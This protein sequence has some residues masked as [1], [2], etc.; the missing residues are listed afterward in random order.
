MQNI[1]YILAV[2]F[3]FAAGCKTESVVNVATEPIEIE[4]AFTKTRLPIE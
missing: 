3:L 2:S 4:I 1:F